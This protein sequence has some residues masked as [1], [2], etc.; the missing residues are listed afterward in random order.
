MRLRP[1][2][3]VAWS[4][5]RAHGVAVTADAGSSGAVLLD[6]RRTMREPSAGG[7]G[8]QVRGGW[9]SRSDPSERVH[10]VLE[11]DDAVCYGLPPTEDDLDLAVQ[12]LADLQIDVVEEAP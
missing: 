9:L 3:A 12:V 11:A 6:V 10:V 4:P 2:G 7:R 8:R 5:H 1:S